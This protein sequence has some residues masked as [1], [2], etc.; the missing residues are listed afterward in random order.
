[1]ALH[2]KHVQ[3]ANLHDLHTTGCNDPCPLVAIE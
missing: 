1:M 3:V 2:G